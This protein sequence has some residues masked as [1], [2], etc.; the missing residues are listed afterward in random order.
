M[1]SEAKLKDE[2][3]PSPSTISKVAEYFHVAESSFAK[4]SA[5]IEKQTI[6]QK[7]PSGNSEH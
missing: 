4:A 5:E 7:K 3:V 6:S 1:K 2:T